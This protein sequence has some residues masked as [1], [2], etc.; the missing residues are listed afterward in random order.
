MNR[1]SLVFILIL[2]LIWAPITITD[3]QSCPVIDDPVC[4]VFPGL[5]TVTARSACVCREDLGG[6]VWYPGKCPG[7]SCPEE[8]RPVCCK[9]PG[10]PVPK[11]ASNACIYRGDYEGTVRSEG[12]CTTILPPFI[13]D[14][15]LQNAP[16]CCLAVG[17]TQPRIVSNKCMCGKGKVVARG[18]CS[19][20]LL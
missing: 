2:S 12:R 14:C 4:C 20:S 8:Y 17:A 10:S 13:K 9:L 7:L 1:R 19:F 16:V 3:A 11:T 5:V 15:T 18:D 6:R